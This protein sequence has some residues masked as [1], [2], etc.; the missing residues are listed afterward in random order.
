MFLNR[1]LEDRDVEY[2]LQN[3]RSGALLAT[4]LEAAFDSRSRRHG[5]LGRERL[6]EG[7]ALVIAPCNAVHTFLMRFPIDVIFVARDGTV[8]KLR[9]RLATGRIAF[10]FRAFAVVECPSGVIV[11]SGTRAG[12][13]LE[14]FPVQPSG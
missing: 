14:V 5:L 8:V 4:R 6:D 10:A 1:M 11:G 13:T 12:D 3:A 2:G 7:A 9:E